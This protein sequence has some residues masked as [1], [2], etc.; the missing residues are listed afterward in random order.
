MGKIEEAKEI[1]NSL[2]VLAKQRNAMCCYVLLAM[3]GIINGIS[4][5][6]AKN[7]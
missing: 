6:G 2:Q 3:V 5:K 1:L 4:W 7:D